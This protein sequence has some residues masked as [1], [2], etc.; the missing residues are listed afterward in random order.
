MEIGIR[1]IPRPPNA[2]DDTTLNQIMGNYVQYMC[3]LA[4]RNCNSS[5]GLLV[6]S[7]FHRY[8][9][10][11][12][13]A[14][15]LAMA[16]CACRLIH[17]I[18]SHY[19]EAITYSYL[20]CRSVRLASEASDIGYGA[21]FLA[22][23]CWIGNSI[24]SANEYIIEEMV[25]HLQGFTASLEYLVGRG[26]NDQEILIMKCSWYC[27]YA[28]LMRLLRRERG[29]GCGHLSTSKLVEIFHRLDKVAVSWF[30][31]SVDERNIPF[32]LQRKYRLCQLKLGVYELQR[33]LDYYYAI[34]EDYTYERQLK[35]AENFASTI[36]DKV[37]QVDDLLSKVDQIERRFHGP[38]LTDS[39]NYDTTLRDAIL[40]YKTF[41]VPRVRV[42]RSTTH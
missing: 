4:K 38:A 36:P 42:A 26:C 24:L 7:L 6:S 22:Q 41:V 23:S 31:L 12:S 10:I 34:R 2:P 17:G 19:E 27:V 5:G 14:I 33:A 1:E 25:L 16:A 28:V 37:H 20:A 13:K 39:E 32:W 3:D 18:R 40:A 8:G 30:Q 15:C 29:R 9:K 21:F 11:I 35:I